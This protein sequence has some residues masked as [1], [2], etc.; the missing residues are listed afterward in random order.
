MKKIIF[1]LTVF[2][3]L[4]A[5]VACS[6]TSTST[7]TTRSSAPLSTEMELLV[8]TFKLEGT[9]LAVSSDQAKQLLPL[10]QTLQSLATSNTAATEEINAVVDQVKST[11]TSQQMAKITAMKLTQ[12][13]VMSIMS[14]AG[15]SP[16]NTGASGTPN[17][18]S[19]SNQ[20]G[21]PGDGVPGGAGG[22]GGGSAPAGGGPSG[23]S[24]PAGGGG[25]PGGDPGAAVG[26]GGQSTTPQAVR[27]G[28][29]DQVP[30]PMLNALIE[31]L[32]KKIK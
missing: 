9:D 20:G 4:F 13:D 19:G 31:L 16:N 17:A 15:L 14:Q 22:S 18:S 8:G 5:L 32:Q 23:G 29:S 24:A 7:G 26:P 12:Q 25:F 21:F 30:A 27:T 3:L 28:M 11:M 1:A 10:W 2:P 6:K